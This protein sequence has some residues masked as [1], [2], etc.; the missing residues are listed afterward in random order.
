MMRQPYSQEFGPFVAQSYDRPF[1][2]LY[3]V[4]VMW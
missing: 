4:Y 2:V 1:E 3:K